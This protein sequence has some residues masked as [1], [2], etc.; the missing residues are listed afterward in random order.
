MGATFLHRR[1]SVP[2]KLEEAP[3]RGSSSLSDTHALWILKALRIHFISPFLM[4]V[5]LIHTVDGGLNDPATVLNLQLSNPCSTLWSVPE[6]HGLLPLTKHIV[7][8]KLW[9]KQFFTRDHQKL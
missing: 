7:E 5:S 9:L 4:H 2:W 3:A 1:V 8:P 6:L